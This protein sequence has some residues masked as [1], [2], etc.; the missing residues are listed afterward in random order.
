MELSS[1]DSI[2]LGLRWAKP[3][4]NGPTPH[5]CTSKWSD[6]MAGSKCET[7]LQ[8]HVESSSAFWEMSF[9]NFS[10]ITCN[11]QCWHICPFYLHRRLGCQNNF[12][13]LSLTSALSFLYLLKLFTFTLLKCIQITFRFIKNHNKSSRHE[14]FFLPSQALTTAAT[15]KT[16]SFHNYTTGESYEGNRHPQMQCHVVSCYSTLK[17]KAAYFS[18]KQT[19]YTKL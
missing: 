9:S 12:L 11:M 18:P 19:L 1:R 5:Y 6:Q 4:L 14:I 3:N 8:L 10:H 2:V 15:N 13:C 16:L 7:F 17:I